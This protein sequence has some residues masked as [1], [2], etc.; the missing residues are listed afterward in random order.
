MS[1]NFLRL[2]ARICL[3]T[4][5]KTRDFRFTETYCLQKAVWLVATR[6]S[7]QVAGLPPVGI[8]GR[9]ARSDQHFGRVLL[10][11]QTY[12]KLKGDFLI[13]AAF[14]VPGDDPEWPEDTWYLHLGDILKNLYTGESYREK[15]KE[16]L[17]IGIVIEFKALQPSNF[18]T[19]EIA[20]LRFKE[21]HG[22]M[23]VPREMEILSDDVNFP[24]ITWG[25][26]LGRIVHNI[27]RGKSCI[28]NRQ[29]L[30]EIGFNFDSN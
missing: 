13:P 18:A 15:A 23:N 29:R 2:S 21:M 4:V 12:K 30:L 5:V 28:V 19:I 25:Y 6:S 3:R 1:H 22:H 20:L 24:K 14:Y 9:T 11:L 26:K 8:V 7:S 17:A 16:L 10:A 27:R